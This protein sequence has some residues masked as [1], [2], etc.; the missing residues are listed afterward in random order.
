MLGL[1]CTTSRCN[2]APKTLEISRQITCCIDAVLCNTIQYHPY[3]HQWGSLPR[4]HLWSKSVSGDTNL[5]ATMPRE[6]ANHLPLS[7]HDLSS[8]PGDIG[9]DTC[10][11][12]WEIMIS[13]PIPLSRLGTLQLFQVHRFDTAW[14]GPFIYLLSLLR[15]IG[16]CKCTNGLEADQYEHSNSSMS[17]QAWIYYLYINIHKLYPL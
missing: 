10:E 11:K 4:Q 15:F 17:L 7:V 12:H 13:Q 2:T 5:P 16:F 3:S 8:M 14:S 6:P 9:H 1:F